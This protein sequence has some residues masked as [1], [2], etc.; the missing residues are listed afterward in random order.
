M[1]L[2]DNDELAEAFRR[3]DREVLHEIYEEFHDDVEKLLR[4]GFTFTSDG[5]TMRF[6]G[7]RE[8]F[9][10][11]EVIQD[12]FIHAFRERVREGYDPSRSYR[13]YLLT[14]VKNHMIDRFR[15]KKLER[16]LF[17]AADAVAE[18]DENE[19]EVLDRIGGEDDD[20]KDPEREA[21][22]S[23]LA[24][25]L[26]TFLEDLNDEDAAIVKHHLLGDL[27]QHEMADHLDTNRNRVRKRIRR[28]RHELLGHLKR[29]GFVGRSEVGDVLQNVAE[30]GLIEAL[31]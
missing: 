30:I 28:I 27:T 15:R 26:E 20:E 21:L 31:A 29:E 2:K 23:E 3:G 6:Q 13:P 4:G 8:P 14:V 18:P 17:V 19:Q 9:R 24:S 7:F 22:R 5:D 1:E 16:D 12:A 25:L 11:R 10:L